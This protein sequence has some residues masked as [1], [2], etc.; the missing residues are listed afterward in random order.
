MREVMLTKWK[1]YY[2]VLTNKTQNVMEKQCK[3]CGKKLDNDFSDYCLDCLK[4]SYSKLVKEK[5][6]QKEDS[7]LNSCNKEEATLI[8]IANIVLTIGIIASIV[9]TF[10]MAYDK[11]GDIQYTGLAITLSTL[12]SSVVTW[13]V[14]LC[15]AK[16]SKN[17]REIRNKLLS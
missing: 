14:V 5:Q 11:Y 8:V 4:F 9:L 10:I 7:V 6:E 13:A 15:I 3:K 1:H 12:L 2:L 16:I 17:I